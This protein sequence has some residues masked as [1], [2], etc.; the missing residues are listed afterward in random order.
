MARAHPEC[1]FIVLVVRRI[2][3]CLWP[4]TAAKF[5]VT[6]GPHRLFASEYA[7]T[8]GHDAVWRTPVFLLKSQVLR[9]RGRGTRIVTNIERIIRMTLSNRLS[10]KRTLGGSLTNC[11]TSFAPCPP[12]NPENFIDQFSRWPGFKVKVSTVYALYHRPVCNFF[13]LLVK[14]TVDDRRIH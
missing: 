9:A 7:R 3:L 12:P 11:L 8:L 10:Q 4:A 5:A 14:P 13:S 1:I 6:N 2:S